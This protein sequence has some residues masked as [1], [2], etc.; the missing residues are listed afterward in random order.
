M[1]D[2]IFEDVDAHFFDADSDGDHDLLVVSGGN[3]YTGKSKYRKPRLYLN[4]GKGLFDAYGNFPELY[5]TGSCAAIADFDKDGDLDIFL[6]TRAVPWKYGMP[7]DSYLLVNDGKGNFTDKTSELAPNLTGLGMVCDAKWAD[8]DSD[9][10]DDL[11]VA[12]EWQAI[13]IFINDNGNLKKRSTKGLAALSGLWRTLSVMDMD[14]DGDLDI[15]AGN[16]GL[17]SKLKAAKNEPLSLYVNDFDMNETVEQIVTCYVDGTEYPFYTRDEMTKQMP[18]LK[19]KYLS[20]QKF[21]EAPVSEMFAQDVIQKAKTYRVNTLESIYA[22]NQGDG[23]FLIKPLP[24]PAQFSAISSFLPLDING[25]GKKDFIA[26]G[27]FYPMNIQIGR[28]D[29]SYGLLILSDSQG[30]FRAVS[31]AQSGFSVPGEVR[32]LRFID[33]SSS[34]FVLAVRNNASPVLFKILSQ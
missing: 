32:A 30:N 3:E 7:A 12:V 4:N 25:D 5:H 19:K 33:S 22:E 29:A 28:Q 23:S 27:N 1:A 8:I 14:G 11:I 20:Y 13:Q 18:S 34:K 24:R 17:N 2:S 10:N 9:G 16:L 15:L 6:G 31:P 26:A 21:A